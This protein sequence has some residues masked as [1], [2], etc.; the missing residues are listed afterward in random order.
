M[1][2][3]GGVVPATRTEQAL[4]AKQHERRECFDP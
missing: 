3:V 4:R 1:Q 2:W